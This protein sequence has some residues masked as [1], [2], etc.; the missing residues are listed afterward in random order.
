M[1]FFDLGGS[2]GRRRESIIIV[3]VGTRIL[4]AAYVHYAEKHTPTLVYEKRIPVEFREGEKPEQ[5]VFR[6]L[7]M[8]AD[9]VVREGAPV[10]KR[11]TGSGSAHEILVSI[12]AP[13]QRT[14]V[15]T[16]YVE[17]KKPFLFTKRLVDAVIEKTRGKVEGK[18]L[19]DESVIGTVLNGYETSAPYGKEA[20]R[21]E[22]VILTSIIDEA[23][24]N[25]IV[26]TL[27]RSFHTR[28]V[29]P[30]AGASLRYQA[31]RTIFPH[32]RDALIL[33]VT[34]P[35]TSIAL[36]R[37][38]FLMSLREVSDSIETV[39]EWTERVKAELMELSRRYPLPRS[40]FLVAREPEAPALQEALAS[41]HLS[42]LW[43]S[44]NPPTIVTVLA[45]HLTELIHVTTTGVPDLVVLLEAVFWQRRFVRGE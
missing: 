25:A 13:W 26:S 23:V 30:I 27:R 4:T 31:I 18:M 33:D 36:V 24:A 2:S 32:E 45:S 16:E 37:H 11:A 5:S 29:F 12:D 28:R 6:S 19:V 40:L 17:D 10:L 15:R 7:K 14:S 38:S 9:L 3:D 35:L 21:A 41:A 42:E 1:S 8:L 43:L 39:G 34:G 44:E 20:H 22:I